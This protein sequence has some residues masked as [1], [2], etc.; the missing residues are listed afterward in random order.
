VLGISL[1]TN[2]TGASIMLVAAVADNGVIGQSGGLPWRLKSD[3]AH[4][5]RVTMGNPVVMGRRT[6]ASIGKPLSGRTNIVVTRDRHFAAVGVVVAPTLEAALAAARGDALRRNADH[7][8]VIGGA[9]LYAQTLN[10]AAKLVIT[11][12][13]LRPQ[14]DTRFPAIDP[15]QWREEARSEHAAGPRDDAAF[16]IVTYARYPRP[17]TDSGRND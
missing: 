2:Q 5:R 15:T 11:H 3:M 16:S 8:V 12:V 9:D 10:R 17:A 4:F 1:Q 14:G 13:H 7:I 6:W